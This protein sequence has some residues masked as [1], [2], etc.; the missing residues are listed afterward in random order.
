MADPFQFELVSPE[1]LLMS[2]PVDLICIAALRLGN[3]DEASNSF[4]SL[5]SAAHPYRIPILLTGEAFSTQ[6]VRKR[7]PH[8][9]FAKNF[10][11]LRRK[12]L[13]A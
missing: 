10:R 9:A 12:A 13:K 2:E 4:E 8:Q 1:R 5:Y 6:K 7:F 3:I 11:S